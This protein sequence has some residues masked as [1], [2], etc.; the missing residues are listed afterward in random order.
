MGDSV[1]LQPRSP[2]TLLIEAMLRNGVPF[3]TIA[4]AVG[5]SRTRV[6]QI[7]NRLRGD[8]GSGT[9]SPENVTNS[10]NQEIVR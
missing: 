3:L 2:Q 9:G 10:A 6:K 7:N 4:K 8:S 1:T 5:V